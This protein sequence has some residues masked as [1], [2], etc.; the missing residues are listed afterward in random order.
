MQRDSTKLQQFIV[1]DAV[2]FNF[3]QLETFHTVIS[4]FAGCIAGVLGLTGIEGL[5]LLTII[6]LLTMI[7]MMLKM[8]MKS[9]R[10]LTNTIYDLEFSMFSGQCLT[11]ILFW[12]STFALVHIY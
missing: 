11:Y 1:G 4:I 10:Y 3:R 2:M 7:G 8:K 6:F 9:S 12:T 5:V